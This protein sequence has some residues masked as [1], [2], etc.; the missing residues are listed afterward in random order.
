MIK[1]TSWE[2]LVWIIIWVFILSFIIIWITNLLINSKDIIN[3][4]ENK[5]T[6]SILKNNTENIIQKIDISK[7]NETEIFY[8]YKDNTVNEYKI[9]T[10]TIN[11]EYKY[12]DTYWNKIDDLINFEW[13]IYS[14]LLLVERDDNIVWDNHQIIKISIKKLIKK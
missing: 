13:H 1:N 7:V 2:S 10:W 8:L 3:K 9:F 11:D 6:I 5:K 14:R 12:I 4:Y